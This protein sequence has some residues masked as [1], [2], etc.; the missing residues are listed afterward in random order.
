M[1]KRGKTKIQD[2][3]L[4]LRKNKDGIFSVTG[5]WS[6]LNYAMGVSNNST[7]VTKK[8]AQRIIDLYNEIYDSNMA[9]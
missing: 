4:H 6:A 9:I 8:I 7:K 5:G 1:Q 3:S 2:V